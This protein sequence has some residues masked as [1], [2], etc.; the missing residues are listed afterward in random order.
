MLGIQDFDLVDQ[1]SIKCSVPRGTEDD[2]LPATH[3]PVPI[4]R[5]YQM[6]IFNKAMSA[7]VI[8]I[9]DTGAGK[10]LIAA[11][12]IRHIHNLDALEKLPRRWSVFLV[13]KVP[14][15]SQQQKYLAGNLNLRVKAF[16]GEMSLDTVRF[17]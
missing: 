7:N 6:E 14:L 11:L 16:Y 3:Q 8:A 13:P 5:T 1:A 4:P 2:D 15:V 12:L 9:L 17:Y 10:T